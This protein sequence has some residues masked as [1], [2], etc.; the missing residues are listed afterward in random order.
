MKK[1][2]SPIG[3]SKNAIISSGTRFHLSAPY[4]RPSSHSLETLVKPQTLGCWVGMTL[5]EPSKGWIKY[6]D[7][8]C[9]MLHVGYIPTW[10]WISNKVSLHCTM[11]HNALLCWD[12]EVYHHYHTIFLLHADEI[13]FSFIIKSIYN[14]ATMKIY[15][16]LGK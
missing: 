13:G 15:L 11:I 9:C 8:G 7:V 12:Q 6:V 4:H 16:S 2:R 3:V 14:I 10:L 1:Q 5:D